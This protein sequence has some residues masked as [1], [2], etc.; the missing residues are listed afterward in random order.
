ME[1][2]IAHGAGGELMNELI[3]K[4]IVKN[5]AGAKLG[6]VDLESLD[7]GASIS[8]ENREIV[9]SI[10]GHVISPIFFPGGDIGKLAACGT[11]NDVA[12]MGATPIALAS[13]VI[14]EEG[15]KT[16]DLVRII[17]SIDA[18]CKKT[19]VSVITGDTKVMERNALD[20]VVIT[21]TGIGIAEKGKVIKDTDLKVGDKIILSGTIGDH[22]ISL[23]SFRE[24]FGF[25]TKLKS[26]IAPVWGMVKK[27]LEVGGIHAMKDP[28]RGG[29][30]S[31]LNEWAKKNNLGITVYEEKVPLK[32]EVIA[33][34]E[35]L[36]IDP[37]IVANEGKVVIGAEADKAKEVLHTIKSNK[38]GKKAEIIGE[39]SERYKGKVV[40]ET[41][42]GGKRVMEP[43]LGDP[44]P[45]VC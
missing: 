34:S 1:I 23:M 24:G 8:L 37:F 13:A 15:F 41:L 20:K 4:F 5:L 27:A 12:V 45:R 17:K 43:P 19:G 22:G 38:L 36:G 16:E 11:I 32:K 40:L 21:T 33:A 42:V 7:D 18:V 35:M 44:I 3:S 29:L 26:D 2:T 9:I 14:M 39:V 10:D 25:E 28:T 31:S 30:S 6:E